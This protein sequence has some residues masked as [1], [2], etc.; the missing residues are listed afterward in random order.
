MFQTNISTVIDV[1][2]EV[3]NDVSRAL[4]PAGLLSARG[5]LSSVTWV[6][7]GKRVPALLR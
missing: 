4:L 6:G 7:A 1:R 2:K 3:R 5:L